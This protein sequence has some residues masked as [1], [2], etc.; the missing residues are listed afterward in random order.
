M[1][2]IKEYRQGMLELLGERGGWIPKAGGV[3]RNHMKE[4]PLQSCI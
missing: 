3:M 4:T 2:I 1:I